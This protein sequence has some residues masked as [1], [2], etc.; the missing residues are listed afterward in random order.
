MHV[1]R[2]FFSSLLLSFFI[3]LLLLFLSLL[4]GA[5]LLL[6]L[7]TIAVAMH[8]LPL[9]SI[10]TGTSVLTVTTSI[11]SVP[12][13][14]CLLDDYASCF[15]SLVLYLVKRCLTH[16]H[17]PSPDVG[18]LASTIPSGFLVLMYR[19]LYSKTL[20]LFIEA[21]IWPVNPKP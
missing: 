8:S 10:I 20:V 17:P 1:Y 12:G 4:L 11:I 3:L 6:A 5:F 18:V 14:G 15:F 13:I 2:Y 16:K 19:N 9:S 21:L 7:G